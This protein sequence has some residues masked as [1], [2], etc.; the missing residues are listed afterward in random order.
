MFLMIDNYDSFVY[1]LVS[2]FE[3][4][5]QKVL[6]IRNDRTDIH[7][8][9]QLYKAGLKGI[10]ISP[11]PKKPQDGGISVDVIRKFSGK[12]PILGV[13]LGHQMIAH[14]FGAVITRGTKPMH[15]KIT[16]VKHVDNRLFKSIPETFNVTRYH[17]LVVKNGSVP[18]TLNVDAV[19]EDGAIMAISH[20]DLPVY[21]I[22]FH[23]EAV[24][25]EYGLTLVRNFVDI[26]VERNP[27]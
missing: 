9:E 8:I 18:D 20:K 10:I 27:K 13:C 22:Q 25:T 4:L 26:C 24:M 2:Y 5:K 23:P 16:P 3:Q 6:T 17:S 19:A 14:H 1:N 15:G 11:G 7:N 21:G 12:A